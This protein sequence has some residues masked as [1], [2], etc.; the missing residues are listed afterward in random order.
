MH[1][2]PLVIDLLA[3]YASL[4]RDGLERSR[5][6]RRIFGEQDRNCLSVRRPRRSRQSASQTGEL[7]RMLSGCVCD[8]KLE[9]AFFFGVRKKCQ[10]LIVG[11]PGDLVLVMFRSTVT[12]R[13]APGRA[14]RFSEIRSVNR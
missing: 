12:C 6:S 13:D 7:A 5:R 11:R 9:L 10:V 1:R 2:Q 4:S 8:I 14:A 3:D